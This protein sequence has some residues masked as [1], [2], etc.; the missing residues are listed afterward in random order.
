MINPDD[1]KNKAIPAIR[2]GFVFIPYFL[3]MGINRNRDDLGKVS[4]LI[5][6]WPTTDQPKPNKL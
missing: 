4:L 2:D 5:V 6:G 3:Q 1:D